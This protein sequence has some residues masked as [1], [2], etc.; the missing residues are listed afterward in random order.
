L[1]NHNVRKNYIKK[2]PDKRLGEKIFLFIKESDFLYEIVFSLIISLVCIFL[3]RFFTQWEYFN[4]KKI[5]VEGTSRISEHAVLGCAGVYEGL[6]IL[7]FNLY[8]AKKRL[9]AIPWISE[10]QISRLLPSEIHIYI[11]EHEPLAVLDVGQKF[12]VSRLGKVY[13]KQSTSDPDNLP[14][15]LGLRYSDINLNEFN[16]IAFKAVMNVLQF[17]QQTGSILPNGFIEKICIDRE[18]G[19]TLYMQPD[20]NRI[21]INRI[22]LGYDNYVEKYNQLEKLL[23]YFEKQEG[24]LSI[25]SVDLT[26]LDRIVVKPIRTESLPNDN[27]EV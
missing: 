12:I 20:N 7:C 21:Q 2:V 19:V 27:K 11:E 18:L 14:V 1:S 4:I 9:L 23:I 15:V 25:D 16:T 13:K 22:R 5:Q 24:L 17:G 26:N 8:A 10:V 3:Y 6:N